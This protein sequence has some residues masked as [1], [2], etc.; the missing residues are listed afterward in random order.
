MK[1]SHLLVLVAV[2]FAGPGTPFAGAQTGT[3]AAASAH[4]TGVI[5]GRVQNVVTGNYLNKARV[6]VKGTDLVT[7]TDESGSY[8]LVDV[9]NGSVTLEVFYTDLDT[10][11]IPLTVS[12]G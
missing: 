7:Y 2:S 5:S 6:T 9:P 8:R 12:P 11:Q 10:Q 4:G 1:H 3:A